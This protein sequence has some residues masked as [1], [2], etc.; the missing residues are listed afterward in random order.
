[1]KTL[2]EYELEDEFTDVKHLCNSYNFNEKE[3]YNPQ[4]VVNYLKRS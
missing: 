1:M 4:S 3:I 2:R